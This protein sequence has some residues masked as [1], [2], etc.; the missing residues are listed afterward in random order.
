VSL[1]SPNSRAQALLAKTVIAN[2][3]ET[4][5]TIAIIPIV[6][7]VMTNNGADINFEYASD[8]PINLTTG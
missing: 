4:I 6:A 1:N 5:I 7:I 3:D 8:V 2:A